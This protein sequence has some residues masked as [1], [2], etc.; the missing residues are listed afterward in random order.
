MASGRRAGS[1][2]RTRCACACTPHRWSGRDAA[3]ATR[4][5]SDPLPPS[6]LARPLRLPPRALLLLSSPLSPCAPGRHHAPLC[7]CVHLC[8]MPVS[9]CVCVCLCMRA[10]VCPAAQVFISPAHSASSYGM[11]SPGPRR[12]HKAGGLAGPKYGFGTDDRFQSS[13]RGLI[14]SPEAPAGSYSLDDARLAE[15]LAHDDAA[16]VRVRL[17]QPPPRRA[18]LHLSLHAK[19]SLSAFSV[20]P[21]PS[22][23]SPASSIGRQ[24]TSRGR[25]APTWGLAAPT[26][27]TRR[28]TRPTRPARART[29]SE[30]AASRR[31]ARCEQGGKGGPRQRAPGGTKAS[32][33]VRRDAHGEGE[34]HRHGRG[35]RARRSTA[36]RLSSAPRDICVRAAAPRH[37]DTAAVREA[38]ASARARARERLSCVCG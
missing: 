33:R 18:G 9:V 13:S 37:R 4:C 10:C 1:R 22:V 6:P 2:P 15:L 5:V 16:Q 34:P 17:L 14:D 7:V 20:S 26:A 3:H 8:D 35:V 29:R 27:S 24:A 31:R 21:G 25:S 38:A 11:G 36:L 32:R 12:G 23:Y 30:R 28:R 19:A